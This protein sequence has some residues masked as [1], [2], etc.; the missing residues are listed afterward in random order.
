MPHLKLMYRGLVVPTVVMSTVGLTS[1]GRTP[2]LLYSNGGGAGLITLILLLFTLALPMLI[3]EF[4]M[5][6][7]LKGPVKMFR[8]VPV[9]QGLALIAI[10]Y[11]VILLPYLAAY[12]SFS[13]YY[14]ITSAVHYDVA[15]RY[16]FSISSKNA[17]AT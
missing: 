2:Y 17:D 10:T 5:G 16:A 14:F 11:V 3:F 4:V 12:A 1:L 8:T 15:F 13:V 9:F 7:S 6:A